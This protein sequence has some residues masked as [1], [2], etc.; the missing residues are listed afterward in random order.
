MIGGRDE[1]MHETLPE[2]SEKKRGSEDSIAV[3]LYV[4]AI[5]T[6]GRAIIF[7]LAL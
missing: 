7:E 5:F 1:G 4:W 3:R 2:N 6:I